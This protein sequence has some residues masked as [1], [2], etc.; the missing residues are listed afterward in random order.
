MGEKDHPTAAAVTQ[1]VG[2]TGRVFHGGPVVNGSRDL[3]PWRF[4]AVVRVLQTS[5]AAAF[6]VKCEIV[7]VARQRAASRC[8]QSG[9]GSRSKEAR[10]SPSRRDWSSRR[11]K[12]PDAR[13]AALPA[14]RIGSSYA[15]GDA[16]RTR[17]QARFERRGVL[18]AHER[19]IGCGTGTPLRLVRSAGL[20][21]WWHRA[22]EP[23]RLRLGDAQPR[24]LQELTLHAKKQ[25]CDRG[26]FHECD[27]RSG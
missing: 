13:F 25:F 23:A 6:D 7:I 20:N 1:L 27:S 2:P 11:P 9:S 18:G 10:R 8:R 22:P 17:R 26:S 12:P 16:P 24:H 5:A 4:M 19:A 15:A 21:T 14:L 3:P